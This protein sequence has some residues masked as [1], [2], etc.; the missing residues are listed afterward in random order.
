MSTNRQLI[1][2]RLLVARVRTSRGFKVRNKWKISGR[3]SCQTPEFCLTFYCSWLTLQSFWLFPDLGCAHFH[4]CFISDGEEFQEKGV[5]MRVCLLVD[6]PV[7]LWMNAV[8]GADAPQCQCFLSWKMWANS[9]NIHFGL[10][11]HLMYTDTSLDSV[12]PAKKKNEACSC[13]I[14]A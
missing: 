6:F 7:S 10:F 2:H 12:F 8:V 9:F 4:R 11:T 3:N 1:N 14:Y 5:G 13:G